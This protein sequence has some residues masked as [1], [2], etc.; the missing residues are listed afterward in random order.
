MV[1]IIGRDLTAA[2]GAQ[3]FYNLVL[4]QPKSTHDWFH[5]RSKRGIGLIVTAGHAWGW[6]VTIGVLIGGVKLAQMWM[7]GY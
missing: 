1:G 5:A 2:A 3:R 4:F 6:G 7:R